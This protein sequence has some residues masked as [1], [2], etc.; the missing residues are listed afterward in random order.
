MEN[1]PLELIYKIFNY[2]P[3]DALYILHMVNKSFKKIIEENYDNEFKYINNEIYMSK[4]W[5][6]YIFKI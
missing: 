1:I 5:I 3:K 4:M 2:L 6:F